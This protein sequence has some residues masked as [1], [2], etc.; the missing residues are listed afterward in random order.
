MDLLIT[1]RNVSFF[2]IY[3][4]VSG[5]LDQRYVFWQLYLMELLGVLIGLGLLEP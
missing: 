4:M 3:S 5:V 1:Y 2:L